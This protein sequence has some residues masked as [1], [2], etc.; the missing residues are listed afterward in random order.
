MKRF[1][2]RF[3]PAGPSHQKWNFAPDH[4]GFADSF[5]PKPL[6]R[7]DTFHSRYVQMLL[8]QDN[9]AKTHNVLAA[10]F[11]WLLLASFIVFPGTF[12]TIQKSIED[13][14]NGHFPS[15][16]AESIFKSVKNVPLLAL[17]AI[18]CSI[19]VIGMASLALR[20]MNNY[21]WILNKLFLPGVANCT[22][23][24]ISTLIGVYT[25][26][27]GVWSISAKVTAIVEGCGLAI[28][29]TIWYVVDHYFLCKVKETHGTHYDEWPKQQDWPQQHSDSFE[30]PSKYHGQKI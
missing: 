1:F 19:S 30:L 27:K 24:L 2:S 23:G 13:N 12:T 10:F 20:H 5:R 11:V 4:H 6:G 16:A 21:V 28:C 3:R 25:Q 7:V 9:V 14:D 29:G 17:A 22:A 26:Q 15:K 18:M 8:D